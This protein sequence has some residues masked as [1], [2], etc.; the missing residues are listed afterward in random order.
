VR[1][2]LE[3]ADGEHR[4]AALTLDTTVVAEPGAVE[5]VTLDAET[6]RLVHRRSAER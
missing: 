1:V 2:T 3:R 6:G 4:E 5:L